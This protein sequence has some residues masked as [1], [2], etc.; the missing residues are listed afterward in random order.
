M[1][2]TFAKKV[3]VIFTTQDTVILDGQSKI[4]N[5]FY[6]KLLDECRNDYKYNGG[7][8]KLLSGRNLRNY[9][10]SLKD[11]YP[12]LK[13]V[14]SSVLKE[15]SSRLKNAYEGFFK[16]NRGYPKYRSW[17]KKWFSLVYDEPNKGWEVVSEGSQLSISLGDIPGMKKE[18]GKRNPSIIGRLSEKISLKDGEIFKTLSVTKEQGKYYAIFTVERCSQEEL[19]FK[20]VMSD[21][22]KELNKSKK[23]GLEK[24]S[25]PEFIEP[26][27]EIP[28]EVK[29]ISLD[30][31]H[32]NF[33]VGVDYKGES[34]EFQKLN[35]IK[36]W[37]R[38]IDRIKSLRDVCE[39][40]Y[41]RKITKNGSKYT[42]HSPRWNRIN[43]ALN[44]AYNTRREQ[45]KTALYSIAHELY[46]RYDLVIIGDYTPTNGTALFKNMKRS[47]LNQEVIGKF[48]KTL[49]WAATKLG[50]YCLVGS[51]YNTT[52]ECCV[53]GDK[54]KK[55]PDVRYFKCKKCGTEMMRDSNSS[56]NIA[57]RAGYTLDLKSYAH[58]LNSFTYTGLAVVGYKV[59]W[60]ENNL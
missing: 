33:F 56:V 25:K 26:K 51:E 53:C 4:C 60:T 46:R 24:P 38:E 48:R 39:K 23:E 11:D 34:I 22:R 44:K 9:G 12:F 28:N 1:S 7:Q 47:M 30:P 58:K 8:K 10:T 31:N 18:K 57:S 35:M 52:K 27:V 49:E 2:L 54:E 59:E 45:I 41:R 42:V 5:W 21:Y 20:K 32:K 16:G 29:W 13:T 43:K 3:E 6:N 19:M 40:K 36:F 37:D 15:P 14:F 55:S 50:K 17:K